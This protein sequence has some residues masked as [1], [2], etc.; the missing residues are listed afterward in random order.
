MDVYFN[1]A[2]LVTQLHTARLFLV[3]PAN[4]VTNTHQ[5]STLLRSMSDV[6][7]AHFQTNH[8]DSI[9]RSLLRDVHSYG[10]ISPITSAALLIVIL[11]HL[12]IG[13]ESFNELPKDT[14]PRNTLI[15]YVIRNISERVNETEAVYFLRYLWNQG[16]SR[17]RLVVDVDKS[18][19]M[20]GFNPYDGFNFS[21]V[22]VNLSTETFLKMNSI[23]INMN[24]FP[25]TGS[26]FHYPP[27]TIMNVSDDGE[28]RVSGIDSLLFATI[29][30]R[31]N[32]SQSFIKKSQIY[33]PSGVWYELQEGRADMV[34]NAQ[35]LRSAENHAGV[36]AYPHKQ[37]KLCPVVPKASR[38]A[39]Y[40]N[41]YLV[42]S[43]TTWTVFS[44]SLLLYV[45]L[46]LTLEEINK[47]VSGIGKETRDRISI[48][49]DAFRILVTGSI[50]V[51]FM[52]LHQNI[53]FINFVFFSIIITN[54]FQGSLTSYLTLPLYMDDLDTL[55]D[56]AESHLKILVL[57]GLTSWLQPRDAN[58]VL[59]Q[60]MPK[61]IPISDLME[62]FKHVGK[63]NNLSI[64]I[65]NTH[66]E[67]W[68][69][70]PQFTK[71][72][73]VLFHEMK[74]CVYNGY[75]AYGVRTHSPLYEYINRII[76]MSLESGL[77]QHWSTIRDNFQSFN[78]VKTAEAFR[79]EH[80]LMAFYILMLGM[81]VSCVF[82]ITEVIIK[83]FIRD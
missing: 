81:L 33:G 83:S 31:L 41:F 75:S 28:I 7:N 34:L 80:L 79:I 61:Y 42:F 70:D 19:Q 78:G 11:P 50:S 24:K 45:I 3:L 5:F 38:V 14:A 77:T 17:L 55:R 6:D 27:T 73:L 22:L 1:L 8:D 63:N 65:D 26:G 74:E 48:V 49:F 20:Y 68:S 29:A 21:G 51:K 69:R 64:I 16:F 44:F 12:K 53:I 43:S 10:A 36:F 18:L 72:G 54:T 32:A 76:S 52:L 67:H 13:L 57:D 23:R 82:F 35:A 9:T 37:T 30:D 62:G 4:T 59:H 71:G 40:K 47:S 58:D 56:L 2:L 15:V 66:F 60:L 46:W 25:I 39:P